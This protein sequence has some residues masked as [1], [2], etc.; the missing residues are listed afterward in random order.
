MHLNCVIFGVS[1]SKEQAVDL[2]VGCNS[3]SCGFINFAYSLISSLGLRKS[4]WNYYHNITVA[5]YVTVY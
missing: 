2:M 5:I 1:V 3:K 4:K